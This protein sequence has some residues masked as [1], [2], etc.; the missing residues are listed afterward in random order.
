MLL[1]MISTTNPIW[2]P[3]QSFRQNDILF[4]PGGSRPPPGAVEAARLLQRGGRAVLS[5]GLTGLGVNYVGA[6]RQG[7]DTFGHNRLYHKS[8][9]LALKIHYHAARE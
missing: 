5:G 3:S 4:L 8:P 7:F 2:I 1:A 9:P 6:G